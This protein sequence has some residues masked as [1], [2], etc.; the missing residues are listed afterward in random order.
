MSEIK[1]WSVSPTNLIGYFREALLALVPIANKIH[2]PWKEPECY[3]DWDEICSA[4]YSSIVIRSVGNT[5]EGNQLFPLLRYNKRS[6]SYDDCSFVGRSDVDGNYAF[7]CLQT[8][9]KPFD[10]CL[11]ARLG[12]ESVVLDHASSKFIDT[13]STIVGRKAGASVV[14]NNLDVLL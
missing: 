10:T 7:L 4:L 14:L 11:F 2:M 6:R 3:D 12:P 9:S 13:T 8:K 1:V 5:T